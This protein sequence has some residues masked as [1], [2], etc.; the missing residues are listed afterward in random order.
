MFEHTFVRKSCASLHVPTAPGFD[1][2]WRLTGCSVGAYSWRIVR[3][4]DRRWRLLALRL[5]FRRCLKIL[6]KTQFFY[7]QPVSFRG[8]VSHEN[9]LRWVAI[10]KCELGSTTER[11]QRHMNTLCFNLGDISEFK[12]LRDFVQNHSVERIPL[13][14]TMDA[15]ITVSGSLDRLSHVYR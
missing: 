5:I 8:T 9:Q 11:H 15:I 7:Y 6:L 13:L 14:M 3:G 1:K 2:Y 12:Q 4:V 10:I